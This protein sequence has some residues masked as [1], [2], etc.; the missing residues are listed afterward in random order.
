MS[1]R[2]ITSQLTRFEVRKG[3]KVLDQHP[4]NLNPG[5]VRDLARS[6]P[7]GQKLTPRFNRG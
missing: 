3:K 5:E 2:R 7:K 6:L 4:R 1:R